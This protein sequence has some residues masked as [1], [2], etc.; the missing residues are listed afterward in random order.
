[1]TFKPTEPQRTVL[2]SLQFTYPEPGSR[3][4][5]TPRV[6]CISALYAD[7]DDIAVE[8]LDDRDEAALLRRFWLSLRPGDQIFAAN[9]AEAL[10]LLRHRSWL[11]DVIPAPQ[12]DLRCV[13]GVE[14]W[15]IGRMWNSGYR[16]RH[17]YIDGHPDSPLELEK[18]GDEVTD[19]EAVVHSRD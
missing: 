15:D 11:L 7:H 8:I 3:S 5:E 18:P 12:I 2:L 14:L 6:T 1:M 9:A 17:L 10:S 16:P 4:T 19:F 13:Y